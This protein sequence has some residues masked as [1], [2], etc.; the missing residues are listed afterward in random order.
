MNLEVGG[1]LDAEESGLMEE[2]ENVW[3]GGGWIRE[4]VDVGV[5]DEEG[6]M[7][8]GEFGAFE[9]MII[10]ERGN[11][12]L[13]LFFLSGNFFFLLVD[14]FVFFSLFFLTLSFFFQL[15]SFSNLVD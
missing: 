13:D 11:L 12:F 6:G 14:F 4:G 8:G 1:G 9:Y 7:E 2:G 5:R 10:G 15:E 3:E